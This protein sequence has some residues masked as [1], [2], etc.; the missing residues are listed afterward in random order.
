M[1]AYSNPAVRTL[2]WIEIVLSL[3]IVLASSWSGLS[4]KFGKKRG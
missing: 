2:A 4:A 1:L 3:T